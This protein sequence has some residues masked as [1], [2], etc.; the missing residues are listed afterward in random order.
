[1]PVREMDRRRLERQD[2]QG[3]L[4]RWDKHL[5]D[6]DW[7]ERLQENRDWKRLCELFRSD[8]EAEL[9]ELNKLKKQLHEQPLTP[10]DAVKLREAVMLMERDRQVM[11]NLISFPAREVDRL[12]EIQKMY[13]A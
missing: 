13:P 9:V 4:D 8:T 2:L 12:L 3:V 1:M 11:E 10:A 5:Q 7:I 6:R